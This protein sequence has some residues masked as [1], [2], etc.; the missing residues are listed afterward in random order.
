[1]II[2]CLALLVLFP[3]NAHDVKNLFFTK[4]DCYKVGEPL[5]KGYLH[6][7]AIHQI[8]FEE[9]GNPE[10]VP[11]LILHGGPGGGCKRVMAQYFDPEFY[12]VIM[13]DQ[14][15]CN[16]STPYA[17]LKDNT[18]QH[19][20]HDIEMLRKHLSITSWI[21][22]GGSYG[23]LLALLYAQTHPECVTHLVL[24]GVFLGRKSEYENILHDMSKFFPEAYEKLLDLFSEDE[25]KDFITSFTK[26]ISVDIYRL[27]NPLP[28]LLCITITYAQ[29]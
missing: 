1:M 26:R 11:V 15:G 10:G 13:F 9:Y 2:L 6:V 27:H 20:V 3:S 14:R 22:T 19:S 17:C 21:V 25:K 29:H 18:P 4:E 8:Y 16:R 7:D 28:M 23:T 24:R 5:S 12:H